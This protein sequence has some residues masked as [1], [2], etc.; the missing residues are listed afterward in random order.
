MIGL[1][2]E[3]ARRESRSQSVCP[4]RVS[5]WTRRSEGVGHMEAKTGRVRVANGE[6]RLHLLSRKGGVSSTFYL[7]KV[8]SPPPFVSKKVA[9]PPPFVSKR[10]RLLHLLS[11]KGGVS[12][13]FCLKKWP[14]PL[15]SKSG[16]SS[17]FCL[18]KW[19]LL[20]LFVSKSGRLLHIFV[21]KSGVSSTFLSQKVASPP[22]F[23]LQCSQ[24][25]R[26]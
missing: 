1:P 16:V 6:M 26:R 14:P 11:R 20:H 22:P 4:A 3:R 8:A 18:E 9:S 2:L 13:T 19:R 25:T 21:S 17:T 12:S 7:K 15:I 23:C 5:T 10:W 24:A